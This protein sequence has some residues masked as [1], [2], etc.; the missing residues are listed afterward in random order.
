MPLTPRAQS[1]AA[2][3]RQS[4]E[5]VIAIPTFD[6]SAQLSSLLAQLVD[7]TGG[8]RDRVLIMVSNN[9]S[10]DSTAAV[11][12]DFAR[13]HPDIAFEV[14]EQEQNIDAIP[15]IHFLVGKAR[16]E[17][18]WCLG[19]DDL[20][21]D[22]ALRRVLSALPSIEGNLF[23]VRTTGIAE[24]GRV[25]SVPGL[26][27][28]RATSEEG[29]RCMMAANFLASALIRTVTWR[30]LRERASAFG[31]PNYANWAAVLLTASSGGTV[32]FLDD[33]TVRGDANMVGEVRFEPYPVLILQR[34]KIWRELHDAGGAERELASPLGPIIA[35]LFF[36]CWRSI[37]AFSDR[38]LP[39]A[40][41]KI[42][43]FAAGARLL[44]WP[45]IRALPWLVV[46][47]VLPA[48]LRA[49]LMRFRR[50]VIG[51]A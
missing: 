37:A 48:S 46:A 13:R 23:L 16:A 33:E 12:D 34:L 20:L 51:K 6:R 42:R 4:F 32:A 38:S 21:F 11:L 17:W 30:G 28:V 36:R 39:Q 15:N 25:P 29:A 44:G 24:W 2:S 41:E 10:A 49:T 35:D 45:A 27:H 43:G 47:L 22:G 40:L 5:L 19:D 8:V 9:H 7:E 26:R 50:R 14:Y 18:T 31:A 3:A 1:P